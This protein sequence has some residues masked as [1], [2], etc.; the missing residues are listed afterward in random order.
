MTSAELADL[1]KQKARQLGFKLVGFTL[2]GTPPHFD[3]FSKWVA[4]GMQAEMH[5]LSN[6]AAIE[7]RRNPL[8]ILP[9]CRSIMVLGLPYADPRTNHPD[10]LDGMDGR[11]AAYAWG[12]DYHD[13]IPEK[14][15]ALV[16]FLEEQVGSPVPNRWYTDTGPILER[17]LAMQAGL[18]W[19]GKNSCLINPTLGS[20]FFLSEILL[21][22]DLPP[23]LA[24]YEDRC[25]SCSRCI[26]ACP[27]GCILPDRTLDAN[28]CISY[29]TIEN[30]GEIPDDQ[31]PLL[32][33]WI[34][35][36]DVCQMVC[37]WNLRFAP[38]EVDSHF[39]PRDDLLNV[40]L[41]QELM[42]TSQEFNHKYRK[43]PI[44]RA[45]RRGFL[46][47][48]A[49]AL[50]NSSKRDALTFL[51]R[52]KNHDEPLVRSSVSWAIDHLKN[53]SGDLSKEEDALTRE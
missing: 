46:R 43:S 4:A 35:G 7:R 51:E 28:R 44:K 50:G 38:R 45:K 12:D 53:I 8:S 9:E 41:G 23:D 11:I 48:I 13:V 21:G 15:Q 42:L 34:F 26:E 49:I 40:S 36:C 39:A 18:G 37:P 20:Y 22:I 3:V 24:F 17:E 31:K 30:K 29:L 14:L 32:G 47:N 5:Y 33:N 27:T 10:R 52:A 19:I 1:L 6:P 16:R 2:P 25:G